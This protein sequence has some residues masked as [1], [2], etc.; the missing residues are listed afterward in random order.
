MESPKIKLFLYKNKITNRV[1]R[2]DTEW[3]NLCYL[4]TWQRINTLSV[5]RTKKNYNPTHRIPINKWVSKRNSYFFKEV[6]I[7]KQQKI[8][9]NFRH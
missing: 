4:Y 3:E 2:Q 5:Q 7:V 9:N 1:K 8:L 6:Q